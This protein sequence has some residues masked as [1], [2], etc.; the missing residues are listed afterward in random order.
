MNNRI[1]VTDDTNL[2]F[3]KLNIGTMNIISTDIE[4]YLKILFTI[5][6]L[7]LLVLLF[8]L[9]F[10]FIINVR[11]KIIDICN[12]NNSNNSNNHRQLNNV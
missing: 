11:E 12:T 4:I 8:K 2:L 1:G 9:S 5:F 7:Y 3:D 10:N 6:S